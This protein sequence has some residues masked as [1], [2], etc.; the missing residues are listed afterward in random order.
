MAIHDEVVAGS[1]QSKEDR[2]I[3]ERKF[4]VVSPNVLDDEKLVKAWKDVITH[5]RIAIVGWSN[6]HRIGLRFADEIKD[7]DIVL[8]A[9]RKQGL[10]DVVGFG[11][12]AGPVTAEQLPPSSQKVY[13]RQLEPFFGVDNVPTEVPFAGVLRHTRALVKMHPESRPDAK[14]VIVWMVQQI[15]LQ[16]GSARAGQ[17][18]TRGSGLPQ[19]RTYGYEVRTRKQVILAQKRERGLLDD[20]ASWLSKKGH[21]LTAL[22]YG[23]LVC[24]GWDE[25]RK[26]LIEAKC[27][28]RREDIR[29]AVGQLLDYRFQ[30]RQSCDRPNMAVLLPKNPPRTHVEWLKP[31]DISVIWRAGSSFA[32]NAN[33]QFT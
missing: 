30:G 32:D 28:T 8:V 12:V 33:G 2:M 13:L 23:R 17:S 11:V 26:N 1:W 16:D 19:S 25:E 4:W 10:P 20:Y 14:A 5:R 18:G 24:D 29:M 31:L 22:A 15:N 27:S 3:V 7:G 6:Q 9:R 21:Q